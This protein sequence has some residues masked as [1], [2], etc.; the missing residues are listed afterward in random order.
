MVISAL[1]HRSLGVKLGFSI[2]I[3]VFETG[4]SIAH[5]GTVIVNPTSKTGKNC[6]IHAC[7]NIGVAAGTNGGAPNIGDNVYIGPGVKMFGEI[8]IADNIA[9]GA[10]AVVNK[11]FTT[12]VITIA[13]IPTKKISDKGSFG[14]IYI[15]ISVCI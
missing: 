11:S 5:V 4:L 14:L 3:N 2:P 12:P 15:I 8:T 9:I 10:N 13:G 7:T 6:R 1:R